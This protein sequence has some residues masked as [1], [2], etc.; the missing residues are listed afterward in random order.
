MHVFV[1]V[2]SHVC[3]SLCRREEEVIQTFFSN[4]IIRVYQSKLRCIYQ[5]AH[6][7]M[8]L[9]HNMEFLAAPQAMTSARLALLTL[10]EMSV[11]PSHQV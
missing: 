4:K 10:Q 8:L 1:S 6:C 5:E 9:Q 2:P 7:H 11:L 3:K